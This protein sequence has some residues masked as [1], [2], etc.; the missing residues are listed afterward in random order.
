MASSAKRSWGRPA[1]IPSCPPPSRRCSRRAWSSARWATCCCARRGP[2][3]LNLSLWVA[4]VAVAAVALHRRAALALDRERVAWLVVGVVFAAGLAWRDAN[5]PEG[6][7]ARLRDVDLR[8]RGSSS[9][10]GLGASRGRAS[11]RRRAGAGRTARV[12]G[13]GACARGCD[14]VHPACRDRP[15]GRLAPGRGRRARPRDRRAARRGVRGAVHVGRRRVRGAGD[16]RGPFRRRADRES[17]P[18]VLDPRVALDRVPARLSDGHGPGRR[19]QI[20]GR[21]STAGALRRRRGWRSASPKSRR[22]WP[23]STCCSSSS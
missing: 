19:P 5:R 16:E 15:C 1:S 6:A 3:G 21:G 13:R 4:S 22:R 14:A 12:D 17:H 2:V 8:A 23:R 20:A 9:R 11:I 7:R 18:A 10:R